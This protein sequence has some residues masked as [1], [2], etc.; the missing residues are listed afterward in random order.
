MLYIN[1]VELEGDDTAADQFAVIVACIIMVRDVLIIL[2]TYA[3]GVLV[4]PMVE[5][6]RTNSF[7]SSKNLVAADSLVTN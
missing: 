3:T 4:R 2:G 6:E 7:R 5:E 1:N